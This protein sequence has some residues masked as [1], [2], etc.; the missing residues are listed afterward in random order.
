MNRDHIYYEGSRPKYIEVHEITN[1][2]KTPYTMEKY[3]QV[4]IS[5]TP[6]QTQGGSR[7][8]KH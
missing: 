3:K 6:P 4:H 2:H 7:R 5:L 8:Q 1:M